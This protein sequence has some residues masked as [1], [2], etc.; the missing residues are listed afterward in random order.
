MFEYAR[1][2]FVDCLAGII[3]KDKQYYLQFVYN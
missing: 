2:M 1:F 3:I